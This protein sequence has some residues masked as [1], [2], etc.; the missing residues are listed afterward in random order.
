MSFSVSAP[1]IPKS[2]PASVPYVQPPPPSSKCWVSDWME[3]LLKKVAQNNLGP[4]VTSRWLYLASVMVYNSYQ[5]VTNGKSPIDQ[6]YWTNTDKGQLSTSLIYL[7]VWM[8]LACQFAFPLLIRDY[9]HLSLPQEEVDAL[10]TSHK[11]NENVNINK[12]SL[13]LLQSAIQS[14]LLARDSDGWKNTFIFNGHLPNGN[15]VI[16][17]DQ[18]VNQ[19]LNTLPELDKWTPL[20]INGVTKNYLTPEW[21]TA[22]KGVLG[23]AEFQDLIDTTSTLFPDDTQYENEMKEVFQIT[24]TLTNTQKMLA[25]YWAGGPHTVT[26][27]GMWMVF[28]DVVIR[29]NGICLV[30]EIKNYA[31]VASGLYQSSITAWRLKRIFMQARPVQKL[32]QYYYDEAIS[33]GWNSE[34]LGQ[35]WLPYQELNFVTPS[36][37]DNPSGHS[38]F[39]STSAKLFCYL[40]GTDQINLKNPVSNLEILRYFSPVL[41]HMTDFSINNVFIFP[42]TSQVLASDPTCGVSLGWS[43]WSDMAQSSGKSRIYGGIHVES[44]NQSGLFL[45][46]SIGDKIWKLLK[47]I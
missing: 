43:T 25:E 27:P 44:S 14:Y 22:N 12:N 39:S 42:K 20:S 7:E 10:I 28:M 40:L 2:V 16:Y 38:T 8:E 19:N 4:T 18:S 26:P 45:G 29:S 37:P 5:F 36:F 32:R 15:N 35:Y 31:V 41:T 23:D 24:N 46:K 1:S 33:Q 30:D 47:D 6:E 3:L 17:A 9:M 34:T 21:G 13:S 11:I